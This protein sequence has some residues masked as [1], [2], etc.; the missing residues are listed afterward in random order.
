MIKISFLVSEG[1]FFIVKP[2][3]IE[4]LSEEGCTNL[5]FL[6]IGFNDIFTFMHVILDYE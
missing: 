6:L 2:Y 5:S 1:L 3:T 4:Y